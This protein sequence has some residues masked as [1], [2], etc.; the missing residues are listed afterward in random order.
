MSES[1]GEG[2]AALVRKNVG[3]PVS[4]VEPRRTWMTPRLFHAPLMSTDLSALGAAS[5]I[6]LLNAANAS[7]SRFSWTRDTQAR[8]RARRDNG[9]APDTAR[10][11]ASAET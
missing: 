3:P 8:N 2:S 1:P 9:D 4:G 11:A 7:S 10:A 5:S 6:K